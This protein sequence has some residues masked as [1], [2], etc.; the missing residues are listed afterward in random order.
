VEKFISKKQIGI[1]FIRGQIAEP[2]K[3]TSVFLFEFRV[4]L[5]ER[6]QAIGF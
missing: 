2:S 1:I 5:Q 4:G 6:A 3:F